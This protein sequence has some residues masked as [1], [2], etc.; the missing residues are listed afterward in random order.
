LILSALLAGT[1]AAQSQQGIIT[2]RI[3]EAGTGRPV[4]AAQVTVVGSN[5]GAQSNNDGVYTIRG[6]PAATVDVRVLCIGF[7][8]QRKPATVRA[9]E[10]TTFDFQLASAPVTLASVVT[11]VTGEQRRVEVGNSIAEVNAAALVE[12]RPITNM[13]DLLVARAP[14]VFVSPGTQTG[15]GTRIRVRGTSSLS[16]TNN[17]IYVIDGI[18]MEG[19]T[20][21]STLSVGGTTPSRIGDL[22]PEEIETIEV[23]KGPSAS[24]LY[25]TDAANGVIVITTKRGVAGRPQWTYYTEQSAITDRNEYPTAYWG[26]RTGTTAATTSTRANTVQC[27]LTQTTSNVCKQDSVTSYNLHDD[28]ESTPFGLGYRQQHGVQVRGGSDAVRYFIHGEYEDE[29]GVTQVTKFDRRWMNAR[30]LALRPEQESPNHLTRITT[31]ANLNAA[32]GTKADIALSAGLISEDLRLPMSDDSGV[33]GIAANTYGGPG[34]K[35]NLD[36]LGDTLYG[37]RAYSTRKVFQAVSDQSIERLLTSAKG[38][39]RPSE[40]LNLRANAG[41]DYTNRVDTQLCRFNECPGVGTDSLGY[42][43]DNRTNFFIYTLDAAATASHTLTPSIQLKTS[44][45]M[46]YYR[47]VFDRNGA[48]ARPLA[49][50]TQTVTAGAVAAADEATSESR[51]FGGFLEQ[52][53][54]FND[55]LFLTAAVRSDR[56]SAFGRNF[57]TVFYP[58]LSASWLISQEDFFPHVGAVNQLRLRAAYGA[59][60]VQPGNNDALPFFTGTTARAESGDQPA[61]VFTALGNQNLKP[62]RSAEF[63]FGFDGTFFDSRVTAE[64]T[65][66]QK[67]SRDALVSRVLPPSLGTG[68]TARFENVGEVRNSGWEAMVTTQVL[69]HDALG[70]EIALNGSTNDNK[71]VSLGGLPNLVLSS[72]LQNREGYPLNGWWSRS[73]SSYGDK[74]GN[75]IIEYN[76]NAALSEIVVSDT[77]EFLGY[78][79]P[80]YEAAVTNTFDLLRRRLHLVALIDYKG[81]HKVYNNSERIRCASRNNCRGLIDPTA[82]AFEQ[83]RT[84]AVREHPSRTVGGFIEDGDFIRFRELSAS[85]VLPEQLTSRIRGRNVTL[86]AAVRTIGILWTRYSGVDPEA[87]GTTGDAPSSFQAFAPPTYLSLRLTFG[88]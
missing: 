29:D 82:P 57:K 4:P 78:S 23:V 14:G 31:R 81:G 3:T 46:Q 42:K 5:L 71:L 69:R 6:V 60:G 54:A 75:G 19:T 7:A 79:A 47:N 2:G 21:S 44:L 68:S 64:I 88:F 27:L 80:K 12:T 72:T 36:A 70:W 50:G 58:K 22:N 34:F 8:D 24:T 66:Y 86:T 20:G 63:E 38:D 26:W 18:R 35:Y 45:G 48:S 37:W 40:W 65:R 41:L 49:I 10:S 62:E 39:W 87:F 15:A 56:N 43:I 85:Y 67:T 13:G 61:L 11:T 83:A 74:N 55:R 16:L 9:A 1:A 73:L 77:A 28:P 17:P 33:S 76:A 51:T 53:V 59:S 30:G 25:G 84:V 32:L 52:N